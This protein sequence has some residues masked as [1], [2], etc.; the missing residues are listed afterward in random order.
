MQH[1]LILTKNMLSEEA[2]VKKLQ[3]MSYETLCSTDLL[4]RLSH[5]STNAVLAYF[6]WVLLS[7]SL[8]NHE[9][10]SILQQLTDYPLIMVRVTENYPNEEDQAFWKERGLSDWLVKEA[11][12]EETREKLSALQ[13]LN[14]QEI[15]SGN[16]ILSFPTGNVAGTSITLEGLYESFSKTEKKVFE[17]LAKAYPDK[18]VLSRKE[19]CEHL[20]RDG[21]TPSNMSQLSCLINKLKR[22]CELQGIQ[23]EI[24]TTLWGRGYM[25]S[26]EFYHRW[27][28]GSQIF[29]MQRY[30][31]AN[32]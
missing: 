1:A 13:Q 8:C 28:Q 7:E 12:F 31:S 23:G 25:L 5:P 21:E 22:K 20:W 3:R 24:V 10:E 19:L 15:E 17:Y 4:S 9:V 2:L 6:Q 18:G 16:R 32:T 14:Q 30:Y 29:D 26:D 27:I 11:G